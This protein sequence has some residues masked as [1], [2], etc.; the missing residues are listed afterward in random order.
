MKKRFFFYIIFIVLSLSSWTLLMFG[1][2]P[3]AISVGFV[4]YAFGGLVLFFHILYNIYILKS[5]SIFRKV[6]YLITI[7]LVSYSFFSLFALSTYK[8]FESIFLSNMEFDLFGNNFDGFSWLLIYLIAVYLTTTAI[9]WE[10]FFRLEIRINTL[11]LF[12]KR[13]IK[14]A[15]K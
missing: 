1:R 14:N 8:S 7:L 13:K 6:I 2:D 12:I 4:E 3:K 5:R 10:I 9:V 11:T 15:F